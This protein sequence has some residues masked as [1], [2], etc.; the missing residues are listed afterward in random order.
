MSSLFT[1]AL[2]NKS[3]GI[4][5]AVAVT[6]ENILNSLNLS[7]EEEKVL[8]EC[9]MCVEYFKE[10][11]VSANILQSNNK[12]LK[13]C[14]S[15]LSLKSPKKIKK[16]LQKFLKRVMNNENDRKSLSA[17]TSKIKEANRNIIYDIPIEEES[18]MW[19]NIHMSET[20]NDSVSSGMSGY[21][22][23]SI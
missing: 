18:V 14:K 13:L 22:N 3:L 11:G 8:N 21:S 23:F 19:K 10:K 6:N 2:N 15:I 20:D 16:L 9:K 12:Q 1:E 7:V 5:F 17:I 4:I